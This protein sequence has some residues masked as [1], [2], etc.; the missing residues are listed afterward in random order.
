MPRIIRTE[1]ICLAAERYKESSKLVTL[2]SRDSG[3]LRV[4]ARGA[5]R[6]K[7][8]FGAALE[9]F[10]VLGA[11][12]YWHENRTVYT[13]SDAELVRSFPGLALVPARFL[14]AEQVI[15]FLLRTGRPHDPA[16]APFHEDTGQLYRLGVVYLDAL[17]RVDAGSRQLVASFLLKAAS[18]LGF[19]PELERCLVCRQ[20]VGEQP[21]SFDPERG[22][23]VCVRC[24]PED[25]ERRVSNAGFGIRTSEFAPVN[26]VLSSRERHA[27]VRLLRRPAAE[28]GSDTA[29]D[30]LRLALGYVSLHLDPLILNSFNWESLE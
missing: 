24:R 17:E 19:R 22:G 16:H 20:P 26:R 18:F 30:F 25:F 28:L 23:V 11:T 7:S 9:R 8:R 4:V 1:A 5:R 6:P 29:H 3:T 12:F 21:V 15:E 2:F 27:L 14:A 10:A 13:L